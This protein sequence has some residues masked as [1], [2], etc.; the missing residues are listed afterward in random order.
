M[1]K[2]TCIKPPTSTKQQ[3]SLIGSQKKMYIGSY[4]SFTDCYAAQIVNRPF[5]S[6]I[7]L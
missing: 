1:V 6:S 7:V 5:D 3:R 2:L 4:I